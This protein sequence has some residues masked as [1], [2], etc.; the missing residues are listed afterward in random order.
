MY[1]LL[2]NTCRLPT[3]GSVPLATRLLTIPQSWLQVRIEP[4]NPPPPVNFLEWDGLVRLCFS[5]KNKTLGAIFRQATTA[6]ALEGNYK[7]FKAL[8]MGAAP[9]VHAAPHSQAIEAMAS[10]AMETS[11]DGD[12]GDEMETDAGAA[13]AGGSGRIGRNRASP[14]FKE[15]LMKVLEE[16]GFDQM[17]SAKMGQEEFLR[18]LAAFNRAGIHFT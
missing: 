1:Q 16:N 13:G 7:T 6:A 8:Q 3:S 4:R 14:E 15:L 12:S 9:Q 5:R 17:R 2:I 18:L 11:D 10:T